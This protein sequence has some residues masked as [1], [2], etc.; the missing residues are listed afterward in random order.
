MPRPPHPSKEA[1]MRTH[2]TRRD[3][4]AL[5]AAFAGT[6][7]GGLIAAAVVLLAQLG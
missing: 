6:L 4:E 2:A 1:G 7:T 3:L 5:A